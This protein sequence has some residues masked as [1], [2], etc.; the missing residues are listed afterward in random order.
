MAKFWAMTVCLLLLELFQISFRHLG[1]LAIYSAFLSN[2]NK[3]LSFWP[4]CLQNEGEI[5]DFYPSFR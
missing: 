2:C 4:V 1:Y 5:H 3:F